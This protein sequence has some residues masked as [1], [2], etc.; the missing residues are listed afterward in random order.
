MFHPLFINIQGRGICLHGGPQI[1]DQGS[2]VLLFLHSL[3]CFAMSL[4][5]NLLLIMPAA[6]QAVS[7]LSPQ[8]Q[9]LQLTKDVRI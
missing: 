2:N 9:S 7:P 3:L 8:L 1:S 5:I 6:L 4:V